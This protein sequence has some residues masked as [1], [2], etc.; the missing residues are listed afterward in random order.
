M[1]EISADGTGNM[2]ARGRLK[3]LV[4]D[5]EQNIREIMQQFLESEGYETRTADSGLDALELLPEFSPHVVFLDI[6]MPE[7]DGLQSLRRIREADPNVE[8]VMISGF[9]TI[10]MARRSLEIG[11]ADYI[12]K[13]MDFHHVREVIRHL[14]ISKFVEFL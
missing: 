7:M 9:A 3:I 11:A 5:D 1:E 6:W 8:V 2:A 13:P 4:V 14:I 10:E 12:G